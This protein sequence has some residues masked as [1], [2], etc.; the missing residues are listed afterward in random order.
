M[1]FLSMGIVA[2]CLLPRARTIAAQESLADFVPAEAILHVSVPEAQSL[3]AKLHSM[4][5]AGLLEDLTVRRGPGPD[6]TDLLTT[7]FVAM[8]FLGSPDGRLKGMVT[9]DLSLTVLPAADTG[10]RVLLLAEVGDNAATFGAVLALMAREPRMT[11]GPA[12]VTPYHDHTIYST[13]AGGD[14]D[15]LSASLVGSR[16]AVTVSPDDG[17]MRSH[18]D[19]VDGRGGDALGTR[20]GYR[21]ATAAADGGAD[22][23]AFVDLGAL[24]TQTPIGAAPNLS[25]ALGL[26]DANMLA[27]GLKFAEDGLRVDGFLPAPGPRLGLLKALSADPAGLTLP[28]FVTADVP[29]SVTVSFDASV[30][31]QEV[32]D[33]LERTNPDAL[34]IVRQALMAVPVNFERDVVGA[35]GHTWTILCAPDRTGRLRYALCVDLADARS[36]RRAWGMVISSYPPLVDPNVAEIDGALIYKLNVGVRHAG[37]AVGPERCFVLGRELVAVTNSMDLANA[38]AHGRAGAGPPPGDDEAFRSLA[39][40]VGPGQGLLFVLAGRPAVR[41]AVQAAGVGDSGDDLVDRYAAPAVLAGTWTDAG[42]SLRG[43]MPHPSAPSGAA[44][45]QP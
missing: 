6:F 37:E 21:A 9:G 27:F 35:L 10:P 15:L 3:P 14:T 4:P 22:V 12:S 25:E 8:V 42:L 43:F 30:L 13:R 31:W 20:A 16:L 32:F 33:H 28:S 23:Q 17:L 26:A 45:E 34:Q 41:A 29:F 39:S 44:A 40:L 2:V 38:L 36:F 11:G 5:Q 7:E 24:A 19:L 1:R 18:L